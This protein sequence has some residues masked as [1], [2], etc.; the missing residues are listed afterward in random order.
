[1]VHANIWQSQ[2][3]EN[4]MT[5]KDMNGDG[6]LKINYWLKMA[7]LIS[8]IFGFMFTVGN[9]Y[10]KAEMHKAIEKALQ[11]QEKE[12]EKIMD[13][14]YKNRAAILRQ[15]PDEVNNMYVLR[16]IQKKNEEK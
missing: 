5:A 9:Y 13:E 4:N 14:V 1:M 12:H 16:G 2:D 7:T 6:T 8:L 11:C 10:L 3:K 15:H